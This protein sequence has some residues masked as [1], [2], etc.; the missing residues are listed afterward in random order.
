[1][2]ESNRE[3]EEEEN[4]TLTQADEI[5]SEDDA[6]NFFVQAGKAGTQW[7]GSSGLLKSSFDIPK[8]NCCHFYS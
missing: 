8:P 3:A 2:L 5:M 4:T 1:M 7:K 6:V